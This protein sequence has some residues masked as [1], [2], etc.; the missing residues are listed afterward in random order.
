MVALQP[1]T[2]L[3]GPEDP[4]VFVLQPTNCIEISLKGMR[5]GIG[6]VT[7]EATGPTPPFRTPTDAPHSGW[8][9][10]RVHALV[11][12]GNSIGGGSS[13]LRLRFDDYGQCELRSVI[14]GVSLTLRLI[15]SDGSR[16]ESGRHQVV[17]AERNLQ[18]PE[19][20]ETLRV[21]L[22]VSTPTIEFAGIVTDGST[23]VSGATVQLQRRLD[24]DFARTKTND[25]GRFRIA[26]FATGAKIEVQAAKRGF[27]LARHTLVADQSEAGIL[28]LLEPSFDLT[29]R[30]VDPDG[31]AVPAYVVYAGD[32]PEA[33]IPTMTTGVTTLDLGRGVRR[34]G[35]LPTGKH[36]FRCTIGRVM[37]EEFEATAGDVVFRVPHLATLRV[38]HRDPNFTKANSLSV[39]FVPVGGRLDRA[40][41][42]G[43]CRPAPQL[44]WVDS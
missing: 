32:A 4:L 21:D 28:L 38:G 25:D 10:P 34:F 40:T 44:G 20:G 14:P 9:P 17:L 23:P 5:S 16:T 7:L 3:H 8:V 35:N 42:G 22:E 27:A 1:V 41:A 19:P 18:T 24:W 15:F 30:V 12:R 26:T 37:V 11:G 36:P 13:S 31:A 33:L 6:G 43:I 39:D 2:H 29:V